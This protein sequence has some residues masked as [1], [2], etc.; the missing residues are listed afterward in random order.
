MIDILI[1]KERADLNEIYAIQDETDTAIVLQDEI[2]E[3]RAKLLDGTYYVA[4]QSTA[5]ELLMTGFMR[6]QEKDFCFIHLA[7]VRTVVGTSEVSVSGENRSFDYILSRY[8][9]DTCM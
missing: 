5:Q 8:V 2:I 3:Q 6:T 1:P 9:G 4:L 7:I